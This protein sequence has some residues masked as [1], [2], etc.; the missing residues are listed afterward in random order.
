MN[1]RM[2]P[3]LLA[4]LA[5]AACSESSE[6]CGAPADMSG[7]WSYT[8][9]QSLP[10]GSVTGTWVL[11]HPE[12]CRVGG[13]FSATVPGEGG[14]PTP[15]SGSVSGLFLDETHIELHLYPTEGGD[16]AHLGILAGDTLT[17]SWQEGA[18]SGAFTAVRSA[19]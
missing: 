11:S 14:I 19:P 10:A 6:D 13:T 9:D 8:A 18:A 16:R 1:A 17:G 3:L 5:V 4:A 12:T 15:L 2:I 7:T